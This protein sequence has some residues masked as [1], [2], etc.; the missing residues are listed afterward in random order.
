[1][2]TGPGDV[3]ESANPTLVADQVYE[4]LA[5]RIFDGDLAAGDR[6][7][8]RDLAEQVGTSVMPVR[9]AIRL[10]VENG[11]AV[12]HPHRGARVRAFTVHELLDLYEVR[13]VL[14]TEAARKGALSV[15]G[16]DLEEMRGACERMY[17]AVVQGRVTEALDEDEN[18]L[19]RL[20]RA[21]GNDVLIA[22]IESL[23]TQCRPYKVIGARA[24]LEAR[25]SSLWTPQ[26]A[27]IDALKAGDADLAVMI[28]RDSL[29]SAR[30]RLEREIQSPEETDGDT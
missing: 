16:E 21:G 19:R 8:V 23:W 20:Y 13:T 24:A 5:Q 30:Q 2:V 6:L 26:P 14:E 17:R 3:S 4:I 10:L 9:E 18:L 27:L 15:T 29:I 22:T 1:M 7:P 28:T 25:D 12:T 11:L